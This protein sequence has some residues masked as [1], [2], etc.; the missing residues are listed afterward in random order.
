MKR[1]QK[2]G[3][4]LSKTQRLLRAQALGNEYLAEVASAL[5]P[6]RPFFCECVRRFLLPDWHGLGKTVIKKRKDKNK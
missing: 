6:E 3:D 5:P 4:T 2:G 1:G